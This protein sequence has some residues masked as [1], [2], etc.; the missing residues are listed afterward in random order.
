MSD[1]VDLERM[2]EKDNILPKA[3]AALNPCRWTEEELIAYHAS[4]RINKY[5]E[6]DLAQRVMEGAINGRIEGKMEMAKRLFQK[7]IDIDL[8]AQ[9]SGLSKEQIAVNF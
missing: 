1:K 7:G 6:A 3:Y 4:E 9:C 8:I 5:N 2:R